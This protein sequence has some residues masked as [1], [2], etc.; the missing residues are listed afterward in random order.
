MP[1]VTETEVLVSEAPD[2]LRS[3]NI[4]RV[5]VKPADSTLPCNKTETEEIIAAMKET[6]MASPAPTPV[7]LP[8]KRKRPIYDFKQ[9][10][11]KIAKHDHNE[12]LDPIV[13]VV[14]DNTEET[15]SVPATTPASAPTPA[16]AVVSNKGK[17]LMR[18]IEIG[19]IK[20]NRLR[21]K[22]EIPSNTFEKPPVPL[23]KAKIEIE[24]KNI[25]VSIQG[26]KPKVQTSS[27][28]LPKLPKK[29]TV[30]E[31]FV[32]KIQ[33]RNRK[34]NFIQE[35]LSKEI[36]MEKEDKPMNN[37]NESCSSYVDLKSSQEVPSEVLPT[38][39]K[40]VKVNPF[41]PKA[42]NRRKPGVFFG[43]RKRKKRNIKTENKNQQPTSSKV[44][45]ETSLSDVGP[46]LECSDSNASIPEQKEKEQ[47][48]INC[49]EKLEDS[50]TDVTVQKTPQESEKS[51][52][53]EFLIE[54][55]I[56]ENKV[57]APISADT[58]ES[59]EPEEIA[60][61]RWHSQQ[62]DAF[63]DLPSSISLGSILSSV[64][65]AS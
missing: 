29:K 9:L 54:A 52:E 28:K 27:K 3:L 57:T 42:K 22:R 36:L 44:D 11:E 55:V 38:E 58:T 49:D 25:V 46:K 34:K 16:P 56:E 12:I 20:Q 2:F 62:S 45:D 65:Q 35:S 37:N 43:S 7:I 6:L 21:R 33:T 10:S 23:K 13:K 30:D 26:K 50:V 53:N 31:N 1:V 18:Q 59:K 63:F 40:K 48:L 61:P 5:P 19:L 60:E 15:V 8:K 14:D 64:N 32:S 51:D 47:D 4:M 41:K 39:S 17:K 24:K